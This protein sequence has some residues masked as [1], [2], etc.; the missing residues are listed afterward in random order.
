MTKRIDLGSGLSYSFFSYGPDWKINEY[1]GG[2]RK[3]D[4]AGI[5]IWRLEP[6]KPGQ[7]K[8]LADKDGMIWNGIGSCWFNTEETR[9]IPS[10]PQI[11]WELISLDPLH[12]EPSVQTYDYVYGDGPKDHP[13]LHGWIRNGKWVSV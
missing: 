4:K 1:K 13:G 2:P 8:E 3:I 12:I 10:P 6:I 9:A 7:V 11:T 5:I